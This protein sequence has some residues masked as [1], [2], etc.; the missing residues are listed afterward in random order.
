ML[1]V[2]CGAW[3]YGT[4]KR[5]ASVRAPCSVSDSAAAASILSHFG[6]NEIQVELSQLKRLVDERAGCGFM[7]TATKMCGNLIAI[8]RSDF[9]NLA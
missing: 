5:R 3:R 4:G 8:E 7:S 1:S 9:E 2:G 6:A